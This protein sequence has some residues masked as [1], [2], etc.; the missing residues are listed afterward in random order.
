MWPLHCSAAA[1]DRNEASARCRAAGSRPATS[2]L[3]A[4]LRESRRGLRLPADCDGGEW[5]VR[6]WP[7]SRSH[8]S[9]SATSFDRIGRGSRASWTSSSRW[10]SLWGCNLTSCPGSPQRSSVQTWK[11]PCCAAGG[12]VTSRSTE[13]RFGRGAVVGHK[14]TFV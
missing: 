8:R 7:R 3:T 1:V 10:S 9:C 5:L 6:R 13:R 11:S 12:C 2:A 14:K 4:P